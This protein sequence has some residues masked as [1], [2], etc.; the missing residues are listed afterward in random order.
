MRLL[1]IDREM[2]EEDCYQDVLEDW[3]QVRI[4]TRVTLETIGLCCG[5][6]STC[7]GTMNQSV[8]SMFALLK[9]SVH[10]ALISDLE[11]N[12]RALSS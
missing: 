10:V 6:E 5:L 11:L 1:E 3:M 12:H 4:L 9:Y 7:G 2:P 8:C